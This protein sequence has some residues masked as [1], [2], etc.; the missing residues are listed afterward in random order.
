MI[1]KKL[2]NDFRSFTV[3]WP[4]VFQNITPWPFV[5]S[6]TPFSSE[7]SVYTF[8]H[9]CYFEK[10]KLFAYPWRSNLNLITSIVILHS[11]FLA[12][13]HFY[14]KFAYW[15]ASF[16]CQHWSSWWLSRPYN[17]SCLD[18]FQGYFRSLWWENEVEF[19]LWYFK[20]FVCFV[21]K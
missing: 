2:S 18:W 17:L 10:C 16:F 5:P 12:P 21:C 7:I 1:R 8:L 19:M 13:T 4:R 20:Q 3:I 11:S 6:P 9:R 15:G 14:I